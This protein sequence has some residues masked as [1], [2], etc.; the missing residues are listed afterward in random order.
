ME[1]Y[2]DWGFRM[3][4][5][6]LQ[7]FKSPKEML[8]TISS[9][10]VTS[11]LFIFLFICFVFIYLFRFFDLRMN[12]RGDKSNPFQIFVGL[13]LIAVLFI[14][15]RGGLQKIALNVSD[16]YFTDDLFADH[17]AINLPWNIG[18]SLLNRNSEKNPFD[19]YPQTKA[20]A[21]FRNLYKDKEESK[22]ILSNDRPNIIFIIM[23]SFTAKFV[24]CLGGEKGVTPQLDSIARDGLLFTHFYASGD[25]SEKG[26]MA[27]LSGYPNQAI[28]SII[29]SPNKT[30]NLPSLAKTL[31]SYGYADSYTYGGEL[32]FANI[33]SYLINTGYK[34][35]LSKYSFPIS[36]RTTSWGVHDQVVFNRFYNDLKKERQP[37]FATIFSL[38][39]H[40]PFDVPLKHFQGE[41][42]T[43]LFRNSIYYADSVLGDFIKKIKKEPYWK[44]SLVL[45]VADHGHPMPGND[46]VDVPSKF[47]IP[48]VLTGGALIKKGTVSTI[49]SQTDIPTTLLDQMEIPSGDFKWGSNLLD[50]TR[51]SFA[52][53]N[54]NNGF[55][56]VTKDG[57]ATVDNVNRKIIRSSPGFDTSQLKYPKA[58]MQIS[59]QDYLDR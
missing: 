21:L 44:N 6:P 51:N 52:F 19:Y 23:E 53:Y 55:G 40:E 29:K 15:I 20:K 8:T 10:P 27:I 16:V 54:F 34:E 42:V 33:K 24:G 12:N 26:L 18:Y 11:L 39:S 49:G 46:P 13:F 59:Y 25:R 58:Y 38:S 41:D 4:A 43:N 7:Y 5:T 30:R 1:L 17:A 45:I 22:N 3:D 47:H 9:A 57:F 14:P 31:G 50:S 28:R 32:E 56:W 35:L 36:E 37:F 48:L 2:T